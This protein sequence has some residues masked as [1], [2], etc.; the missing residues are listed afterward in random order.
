V[1][2]A[3]YAKYYSGRDIQEL[4]QLLEPLEG[5]WI[6]DLCGGDGRLAKAALEAG[7]SSGLLVDASKDMASAAQRYPHLL[8]RVQPVHDA[9][10]GLRMRGARYDRVVCRQ[11]VNY[12]L[13]ESAAGLVSRVLKPGGIFAFNTFNEKPTTLPRTKAYEYGGHSFVE[14][15]WLVGDMVHHVQVRDGMEPHCTSFRWIPPEE[16][17]ALLAP[18][19]EVEEHR[20]GKTSLYKCTRK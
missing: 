13:N 14:I 9:L 1:Y 20:E 5:S 6:I 19:F 12:W 17:H 18:H 15:S 8:I 10:I 2:E 16:F 11:A 4:L 3:L 7:A